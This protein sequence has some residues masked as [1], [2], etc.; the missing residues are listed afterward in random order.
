MPRKAVYEQSF[1]TDKRISSDPLDDEIIERLLNM[2]IT[3]I[4]IH[5]TNDGLVRAY[6][7]IVFDNCFM[8]G[9]IRVMQGPT[10]LFVSFPAKKQRDG[11]DRQLAYP[12]NA[13]T[14][15]MIQRVILAE[16]EKIVAGSDPVPTVR[17]PSERL[18]ALEQLKKDGLINEEEYNGKRKEILG[19]L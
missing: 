6:V 18:R 12:A 9:E 16:Y 13:K 4:T 3:E 8:V 2:E 17:S 7:D 1:G 11:S 14:R 19:D 15:M 10:G 5:P